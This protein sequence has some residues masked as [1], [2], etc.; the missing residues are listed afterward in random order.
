MI[1]LFKKIL[2]IIK[3]IY[4]SYN[5]YDIIYSTKGILKILINYFV[6]LKN[7][8]TILFTMI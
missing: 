5:K 4:K 3:I 6:F 8:S 2:D 7:M 1:L